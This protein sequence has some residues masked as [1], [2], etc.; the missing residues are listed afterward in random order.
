VRKLKDELD[1]KLK[2]LDSQDPSAVARAIGLSCMLLG[3]GAKREQLP[4]DFR[5][6]VQQLA[7]LTDSSTFE[8]RVRSKKRCSDAC[9]QVCAHV[10]TRRP[11]DSCRCQG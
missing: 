5:E 8:V 11:I 6:R 1:D 3:Q 2:D 4:D 7:E 9:L 10:A